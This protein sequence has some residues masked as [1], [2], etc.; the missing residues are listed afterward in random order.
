MKIGHDTLI[1][2]LLIVA[3]ALTIAYAQANAKNLR[4]AALVGAVVTI[5]IGLLLLFGLA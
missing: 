3:G 2:V 5:V 1:G 4:V